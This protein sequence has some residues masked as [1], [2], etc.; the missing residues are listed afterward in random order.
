MLENSATLRVTPGPLAALG[1]QVALLAAL[2]EI[3]GLGPVGWVVG[4]AS[5]LVLHEALAR[6]LQ[7]DPAA[8]LGTASWVTLARATL[9]V[10]V[11]ALAADSIGRDT[12]VAPL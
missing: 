2:A 3:V 10:G 7:R 12:A 1:A 11:A 8:R 5:A 4:L 6:A 9:A